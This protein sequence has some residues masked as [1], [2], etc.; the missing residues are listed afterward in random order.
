M[1]A[2]QARNPQATID[3][4]E[5]FSTELPPIGATSVAA[6]KNAMSGRDNSDE[7]ATSW[8]LTQQMIH[9]FTAADHYLFS[10]PMWNFGIPYVLKHFIDVVTQPGLTFRLSARDGYSGLLAGRS[11]CVVYT[12]GVY[13][14]GCPPAFGADFQSSYLNYWLRFLGLDQVTEISLRPTDFTRCLPADLERARQQ[15][16]AAAAAL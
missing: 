10:V 16:R 13:T 7:E 4:I 15:A 2:F 5:L 3:V 6:K 14:P 12:S 1:Q 8:R 11:A 9:R